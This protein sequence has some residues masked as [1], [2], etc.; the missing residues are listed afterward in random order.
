MVP[1]QTF[2]QSQLT[3]YKRTGTS[4]REWASS[5]TFSDPSVTINLQHE[6]GRSVI[7]DLIKDADVFVEN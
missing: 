6:A 4:G 2:H 3:F 1:G 7:M 5:S